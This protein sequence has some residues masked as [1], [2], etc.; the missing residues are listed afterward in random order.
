MQ[1]CVIRTLPSVE[2]FPAER[3]DSRCAKM[4][5][6]RE[7][8][9]DRETERERRRGRER[10]GR[11]GEGGRD[12]AIKSER[13]NRAGH[14]RD[15]ERVCGRSLFRDGRRDLPFSSSREPQKDSLLLLLLTLAGTR[16]RPQN[17]ARRLAHQAGSDRFYRR[18]RIPR[19]VFVWPQQ[20]NNKAAKQHANPSSSLRQAPAAH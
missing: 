20:S 8:Q 9:R 3:G 19:S 10:G 11:G 12:P 6:P 7:R 14:A 17:E 2:N 1:I 4:R 18:D 15:R 13:I 16:E 5:K